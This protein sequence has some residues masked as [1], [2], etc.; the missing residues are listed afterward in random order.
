[1]ERWF[2]EQQPTV[3]VLAAAKVGGI[4]ANSTYP[5]DFLLNNLKIQTYVIET[6]WR[7]GVRRFLFLGSSCTYPKFAAQPIREEA[8][9]TGALE[10]TNEWYAIAKITGMMCVR[11]CGAS[12]ALMPSA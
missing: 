2:A 9:L 11:R 6:T 5:A 10:P 8:L 4:A 1:M 7:S 3:V 12:T